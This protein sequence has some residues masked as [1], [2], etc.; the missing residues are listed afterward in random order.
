MGEVVTKVNGDVATGFESVADEVARHA[1][2]GVESGGALAVCLHGSPVVD[3]W[4]GEARP[5]RQWTMET[6]CVMMSAT[7]GVT[8]LCAQ[9]LAD[10]GRLDVDA[11]VARYWPE[12]AEAGKD[13]T[14]VRHVLA[15]TAG[16]L[17]FPRY[18][19]VIGPEARELT[20]WRTITRRL[21]AAPAS[22]E[23]GTGFQY[24]PLTFGYLVGELIRR[25]SGRTVGRFVAEELA[26]PLGLDL[27]I[28]IPDPVRE[29]V[30]TIIAED[31]DEN[32]RLA[33]LQARADR[34]AQ[35]L[36]LGGRELDPAATPYSGLFMWPGRMES[37]GYLAALMNDPGLRAAELPACNGIATARSLCRLYGVL[38]MDGE[39]DGVRLVSAAS[40][41]RF[42]EPQSPAGGN[43]G[44]FGLGYMR[45][46][47]TTLARP[48]DLEV[49]PG[50]RTIGH[51][52]TGGALGFADR[53][54]GLAFAYLKNRMLR[55]PTPTYDLVRAV[56]RCL[57]P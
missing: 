33:R 12:F 8:A 49:R 11:P 28:G 52:G 26:V 25:V 17:S 23:P 35:E 46:P 20:D 48:G 15:H 55:L 44:G 34:R 56:Y 53:D 4:F 29:R 40:I 30:A 43:D 14:L 18:W 21:A 31:R 9:I 38:S 24:A 47:M 19:E 39:L 2:A 37:V 45:L 54:N 3:V 10:R 16:V 1:R 32:P 7:K 13:H 22:W 42:T 57:T 36:V 51:T 41:D 50:S 6:A 5:S 27:W